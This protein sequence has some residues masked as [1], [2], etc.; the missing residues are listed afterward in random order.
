MQ[1]SAPG[2]LVLSEVERIDPLRFMARCC[3]RRL[4]QLRLSSFLASV[5]FVCLVLF[6]RVTFRVVILCLFVFCLLVVLR[7]VVGTSA[8]D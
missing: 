6:T 4:N 2:C 8:S 1:A 5:S 3:K 7:L